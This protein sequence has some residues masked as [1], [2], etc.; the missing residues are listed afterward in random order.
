[1]NKRCPFCGKPVFSVWNLET[2]GEVKCL[3]KECEGRFN[4]KPEDCIDTS[5]DEE[6]LLGIEDLNEVE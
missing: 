1:M 4:M 2:T 3:D 5:E 6:T